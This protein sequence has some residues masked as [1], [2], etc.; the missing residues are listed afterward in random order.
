MNKRKRKSQ[1]LIMLKKIKHILPPSKIIMK[2]STHL[3]PPQNIIITQSTRQRNNGLLQ[4]LI[5]PMKLPNQKN[6]KTLKINYSLGQF[7]IFL[8][9]LD[10]DKFQQVLHQ[11]KNVFLETFYKGNTSRLDFKKETNPRNS[12]SQKDIS[13]GFFN[14][15][16]EI[17]STQNVLDFL[18]YR[19]SRR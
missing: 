6:N 2:N 17:N 3:L 5:D 14:T 7:S 16:R 8:F 9:C 13:R 18:T 15:P 1:K 11:I 4:C 12:Q 10:Q 19:T